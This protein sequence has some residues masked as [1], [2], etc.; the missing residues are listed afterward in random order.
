[1]GVNLTPII[2]KK[3]TNLD[4]LRGRTMAV[5]AFNVLYQFLALIRTRTGTPLTDNQGNITSH[6]IGL[7]FR[8][9]RLITDY[10][11]TPVFV[12]DGKPPDLKKVE[13]E[14][15]RQRKN[16]AEK[17]YQKA[18]ER[19][20]Y[21]TAW[22]K[23]VQTSRLTYNM[24]E[25]A[26]HLI[27]LLGVPWVQAPSEGEAQAAYMA[28][29]GDVWATSSRDYDSLL[30]GAPRVVRYLTIQGQEWLPSKGR[31]R[32]LEPE[33]I[34]LDELLTHLDLTRWQLIDAAILIGTDFNP[35]IKG[36]GPKTAIKLLK[37][38]GKLEALPPEIMEKLTPRYQEI[39]E[40]YKNP[41]IE[42]EYSTEMHP[43]RSRELYSFL[44]DERNF[45]RERVDVLVKRMENPARQRSLSDWIR[46]VP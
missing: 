30:F 43:P 17:D 11:I 31:A 38:H 3:V 36:I 7:A 15:R 40:F 37:K 44:C 28:C 39:R 8:T 4:L 22:R 32:K 35:G 20:D 34:T 27:S 2:I 10:N 16:Q 41:P 42:D 25:D 19:E 1:M 29:R 13:I 14:N 24:I 33:I 23:A 46:E 12:F 6:L 5:D 9:T 26:K 18:V 21:A 45:S